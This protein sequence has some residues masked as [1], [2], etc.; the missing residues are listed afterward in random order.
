M[1]EVIEVLNPA[2]L[3]GIPDIWKLFEQLYP[4]GGDLLPGGAEAIAGD[5]AEDITSDSA[6]I[7]VGY[8]NAKPVGFIHV[9][10]PNPPWE[11]EPVC[12]GWVN[13]GRKAT[14][15]AMI[16]KGV[17]FLRER[18]YSSF[19]ALNSTDKADSIWARSFRRVTKPGTRLCS[20]MR[21]EFK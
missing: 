10:L 19:R 14:G 17:E 7:L 16:D 11:P 1:A 20:V 3:R 9:R 4:E 6:I 15:R 5:L 2:A 8:E 21:F 18:G 12:V 13:N